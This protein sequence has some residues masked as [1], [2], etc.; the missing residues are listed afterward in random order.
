M[1]PRIRW[2]SFAVL[3]LLT[4]AS[5]C[6]AAEGESA[7]KPGKGGAV[8]RTKLRHL[9]KGSIVDK[10]FK[11]GE[12]FE[13]VDVE[14][15]KKQYLYKEGEEFVFMD[16][17]TY[18]QIQVTKELLGDGNFGGSYMKPDADM[19]RIWQVAVEETRE[20]IGGNWEK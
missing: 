3:V 6:L 5:A 11:S 20:V 14:R 7:Y 4:V 16:N 17:E 12:R 13:N 2:V 19:A 18:D 9:T 1:I 15:R 10:T 8:M